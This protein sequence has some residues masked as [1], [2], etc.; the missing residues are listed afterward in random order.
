MKW[1]IVI[2]DTSEAFDDEPSS[3]MARILRTLADQFEKHGHPNGP[4]DG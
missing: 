4:I 3:E 1:R 2:D